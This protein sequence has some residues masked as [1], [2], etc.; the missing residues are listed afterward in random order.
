MT[1]NPYD[2]PW[3]LKHRDKY[4]KEMYEFLRHSGVIMS[5]FGGK[6]PESNTALNV[7]VEGDEELEDLVQPIR[8]YWQNREPPSDKA[9]FAELYYIFCK[10]Q[11]L[12]KAEV[13]TVYRFWNT[14]LSFLVFERKIWRNEVTSMKEYMEHVMWKLLVCGGNRRKYVPGK[15]LE[16]LTSS[17]T[18]EHML[19]WYPVIFYILSRA[20]RS[21]N[22]AFQNRSENWWTSFELAENTIFDRLNVRKYSG[23][24][25]Q[26]L[27][28]GVEQHPHGWNG[29]LTPEFLCKFDQPSFTDLVSLSLYL[30]PRYRNVLFEQVEKHSFCYMLA[31]HLSSVGKTTFLRDVHRFWTK[32]I[33][34]P[35]VP[36]IEK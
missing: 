23:F 26:L 8:K 9:P 35:F 5:A 33:E 13:I 12:Y 21:V 28:N 2:I 25:E 18:E 34:H 6:M 32:C 1:A 19:N 31:Y 16:F 17:T 22:V 7:F 10:Y 15:S 11:V 29:Q 24:Q 30:A 14:Y 27:K 3:E 4:P 20:W 36:P